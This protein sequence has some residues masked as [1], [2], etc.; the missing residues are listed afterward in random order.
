MPSARGGHKVKPAKTAQTESTTSASAPKPTRWRTG[1]LKPTLLSRNNSE[2]KLAGVVRDQVLPILEPSRP[3][4]ATIQA[5]STTL[6]EPNAVAA[7]PDTSVRDTTPE[8]YVTLEVAITPTETIAMR[9]SATLNAYTRN[10]ITSIKLE[11]NARQNSI[12]ELSMPSERQEDTPE[13]TLDTSHDLDVDEAQSSASSSYSRDRVSVYS[14]DSASIYSSASSIYSSCASIYSVEEDVPNAFEFRASGKLQYPQR[15]LPRTGAVRRQEAQDAAS[16]ERSTLAKKAAMFKNSRLSPDIPSFSTALPTWSMV[17][18]AAQASDDCYD[19]GASTRRGT[20]TQAN[21][22]KSIK[23]MI[24]DDQLIDDTRVIIVAIRGTQFQC[25]SD[26][27]VNKD[28][29]PISPVGFL[30]DEENACHSGFLQVAKAMTSQ[31]ST[32]LHQHPASLEKPSLL[33]T[34]HSAGGAVAA[35][36]YSHMLSSSVTSELTTLANLFSS[37]NCIIFG[38]PPLS[39]TSL[40]KR[41]HISGVFL[42][43]ANEGDPVTRLSN[44][45]YVKSLVKLLT[46]STPSNSTIAAPVKVVRGSRGTRVIRTTLPTTPQTPWEELPMWS[47]PPAPLTNAGNV[48]LLREKESGDTV[49]SH[50]TAEE[51]SDVIFADLAQHTMGMY[52]RRV[53]DVAFAAMMGIED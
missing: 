32:Q 41:D 19:S 4:T 37:I 12:Q 44:G 30:D 29:D 49:A 3:K 43:F 16:R 46:A 27:S 10:A 25:L 21:T 14:S 52:M 45:A 47:T 13:M 28:A 2:P 53:K 26:W 22:S 33:F 42:S 8:L 40:P 31:V 17:C 23:A 18:R 9:T 7:P 48:I 24:V 1:L 15:T 5:L 51:L 11:S 50:I 34:G 38:A 35:M 39:L 6:P 36:L 20:Y